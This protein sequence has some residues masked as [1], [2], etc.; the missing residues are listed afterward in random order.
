MPVGRY[1]VEI[2]GL[3]IKTGNTWWVSP[4]DGGIQGLQVVN[5]ENVYN[6]DHDAGSVIG[7]EFAAPMLVTIPMVCTE[8]SIEAAEAAYETL[9]AAFAP[10]TT[11]IPVRFYLPGRGNLTVD[12]VPRDGL[13][14]NRSQ[15]AYG[16]IRTLAKI[17]VPNPVITES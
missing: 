2:R 11:P 17:Y 8:P 9:E 3:V 12:G 10:S 1:E 6:L 13:S 5:K 14:P 4:D 15:V 7:P 16:L